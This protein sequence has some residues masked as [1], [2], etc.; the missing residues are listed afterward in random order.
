MLASTLA[1]A[2]G[3]MEPGFG[4]ASSHVRADAPR[5]A[6]QN[7]ASPASLTTSRQKCGTCAVVGEPYGGVSHQFRRQVVSQ[8]RVV[9]RADRAVEGIVR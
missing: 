2:G 7:V 6:R 9:I 1:L 8:A 4:P 3:T 5:E